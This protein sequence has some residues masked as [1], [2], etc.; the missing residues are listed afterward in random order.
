[1]G[2]LLDPLKIKHHHWSGSLNVLESL[3]SSSTVV[4]LGREVE[5]SQDYF[6]PQSFLDKNW[7]KRNLVDIAKAEHHGSTRKCL[8]ATK[9]AVLGMELYFAR[10]EKR[11][12]TLHYTDH[13]MVGE[14]G[15]GG[16]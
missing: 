14:C 2:L 1:M 13:L 7:M 11:E 6:I 8:V 15:D 5:S 10:G 3:F 12:Q 4:S 9:A 16:G